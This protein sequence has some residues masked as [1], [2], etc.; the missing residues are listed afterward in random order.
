MGH[1]PR[2]AVICGTVL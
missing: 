2:N 1:G